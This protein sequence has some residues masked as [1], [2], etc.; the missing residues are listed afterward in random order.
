MPTLLFA[1][2]ETL[3]LVLVSGVV[4]AEIRRAPVLAGVDSQGRIW[5][6]PD[7]A[8]PRESI[9][10][11]ARLGVPIL[12][13]KPEIGLNRVSCW[14]QLLPLQACAEAQPQIVLFELPVSDLARVSAE[15]HRFAPTAELTYDTQGL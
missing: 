8:L 4:P 13:R 6:Q 3:R 5:V 10:A 2:L 15:I 14:P 1:D 9:S 12:G 11:L 7:A